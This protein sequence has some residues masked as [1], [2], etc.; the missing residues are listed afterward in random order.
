VIRPEI[1]TVPSSVP[2]LSNEVTTGEFS[3]SSTTRVSQGESRAESRKLQEP[4]EKELFRTS[5]KSDTIRA[6]V[7]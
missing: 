4:R 1:L 7:I 6:E 3:C 2:K 5:G